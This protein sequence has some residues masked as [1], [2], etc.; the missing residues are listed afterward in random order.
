MRAVVSLFALVAA[1]ASSSALAQRTAFYVGNGPGAQ[2]AQVNGYDENGRLTIGTQP[3]DGFRGGVRVAAGDVNGDGRADIVTGAGPGGGPHVRVFDGA[4]GNEIRGFFAYDAG[5]AGGVNVTAGDLDGDGRA[6]VVTGAGAGGGPHVK[7]F[8]GATGAETRSF[9][10]FEA[11]FTGGVNVAVGDF[12]GDGQS[13]LIVVAASGGGPQVRVFDGAT[14]DLRASFFAFDPAF[15]GGVSIAT[16]R[17]QGQSALFAGAGTGGESRVNIFN[18]RDGRL[19]GSLLAFDPGFTG[20]VNVSFATIGG[21]D[22]LLAAM[23]SRG[24]T[25]EM[26]DVGPRRPGDR[27]L[28]ALATGSF[29]PFGAD[30]MDGLTIAGVVAPVPEPA[31]WAQMLLGF[32]LLGLFRRRRLAARAVLG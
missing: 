32:G 8:S 9:F 29:T 17:F 1:S 21:R 2:V 7:V 23:A 28:E 20:G 6:D 10:A 4:T 5:F 13:D 24:G 12:G 31:S 3:Y 19:I 22:T 25:V 30:Y 26:F 14:N 15:T 18:L 11:G 16:G 27:T